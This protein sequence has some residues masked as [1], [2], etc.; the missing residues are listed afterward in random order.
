M[1]KDTSGYGTLP[2]QGWYRA[3]TADIA[4]PKPLVFQ[5]SS[6]SFLSTQ[7]GQIVLGIVKNRGWTA[8]AS[9]GGK[10]LELFPT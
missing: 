7:R 3:A 5:W 1:P 8:L 6:Q 10:E 4:V 9:L 2:S